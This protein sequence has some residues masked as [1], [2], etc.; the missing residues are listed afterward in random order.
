MIYNYWNAIFG[1]KNNIKFVKWEKTEI[2][3][4]YIRRKVW[5]I[6]K[7][8]ITE[9]AANISLNYSLNYKT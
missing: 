6:N 4:R 9:S 7:F 3:F 8:I 2:F 1:Y 5:T